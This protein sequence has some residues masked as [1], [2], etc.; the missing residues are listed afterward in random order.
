VQK[1]KESTDNAERKMTTPRASFYAGKKK[2]RQ[3][4]CASSR[5]LLLDEKSAM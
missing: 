4:L 3:V 1:T 5:H 2:V